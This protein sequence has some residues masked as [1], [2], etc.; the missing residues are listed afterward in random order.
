MP[1]YGVGM[2]Y[3]DLDKLRIEMM[4]RN[5][6]VTDLC[7]YANVERA[8]VNRIAHQLPITMEAAASINEA[9]KRIEVTTEL[10]DLFAP[11][12]PRP[13][14]LIEPGEPAEPAA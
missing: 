6:S 10:L 12:P 5:V 11:S 14:R 1:R 4:K 2:V 13:G 7:R 9:L 3:V 8:T